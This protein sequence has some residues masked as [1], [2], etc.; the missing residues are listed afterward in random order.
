MK[1][2]ELKMLFKVEVDEEVS[3]CLLHESF[4]ARYVELLENDLDYIGQWMQWPYL[5]NTEES[6]KAFIK[7]SLHKYADGT[8]I[9]YAIEFK[10][11]IVGNC[12]FNVIN[13]ELKNAEIGY[14]LGKNYQG[15][16]IIT[17][18]CRYLIEYAFTEMAM[19]KVQISAAKENKASRAVCERL[20][21]T[22]EGIIT[23]RE[24][25]QDRI[26]DHAIYGIYN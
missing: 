1:N 16:G 25:I 3:L 7:S 13:H 21:M 12:G 14:W 4:A 22:L 11:E 24:K 15:N 23:Q 9:N 18:A 5:C 26:L 2:K 6:F 20:G 17:R 10:G 8:S 19:K